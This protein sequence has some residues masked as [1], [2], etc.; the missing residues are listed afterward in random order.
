ML[1]FGGGLNALALLF[2]FE[3]EEETEEQPSPTPSASI[4]E[5]CRFWPAC[6]NGSACQYIHPSIPCK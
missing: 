5:R 4:L 2:C 1:L 6:V 3:D